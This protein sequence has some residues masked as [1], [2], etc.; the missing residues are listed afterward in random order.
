MKLTNVVFS[1]DLLKDNCH[2][3]R[4]EK[5]NMCFRRLKIGNLFFHPKTSNQK[6]KKAKKI[7]KQTNKKH[8]INK[9]QIQYMIQKI[10]V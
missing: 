3:R 6:N 10:Y 4:S 8:N 1:I 9:F 5:K 7:K 2:L